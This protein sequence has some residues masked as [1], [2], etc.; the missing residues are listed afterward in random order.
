MGEVKLQHCIDCG[1]PKPL[2][3]FGWSKKRQR[4][5]KRCIECWGTTN[6]DSVLKRDRL[7]PSLIPMYE[8]LS[9]LM[10]QI[11][12][13][14]FEELVKSEWDEQAM[15]LIMRAL[16][17]RAANG[18][19]KAIEIIINTRLKLKAQGDGSEEDIVNLAQLLASDPLGADP[20]TA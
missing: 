2:S 3:E 4:P 19:T 16:V 17:D 15:R 9:L 7:V 10:E 1:T 14:S 18:D 12:K 8:E 11:H 13:A 6:P 5:T 20:S